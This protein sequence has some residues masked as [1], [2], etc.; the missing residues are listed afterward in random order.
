MTQPH[1]HGCQFV[2]VWPQHCCT[3]F[4][5]QMLPA[6]CAPCAGQCAI[7]SC[8]WCSL[9]QV[10]TDTFGPTALLDV[11]VGAQGECDRQGV[12]MLARYLEAK[13]VQQLVAEAQSS[14]R[15]SMGPGGAAGGGGSRL[16]PK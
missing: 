14:K 2:Y 6:R 8:C 3:S 9:L 13:R 12:R 1:D 4:T 16:E 11:V 15:S 7:P 10:I 5:R